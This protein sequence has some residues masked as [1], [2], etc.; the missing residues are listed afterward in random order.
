M[1]SYLFYKKIGHLQQIVLE[2]KVF[3]KERTV[4]C[5]VVQHAPAIRYY[6]EPSAVVLSAVVVWFGS[7]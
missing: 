3:F 5:F 2:K 6:S 4:N 1:R 7:L